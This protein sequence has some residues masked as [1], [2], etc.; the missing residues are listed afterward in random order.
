MRTFG[1]DAFRAAIA[2]GIALAEH[3]EARLRERDG[4]EV[5]TPASLG[6]VTFRRDGLD[7]GAHTRLSAATVE[8][9]YAAPS[10]TVVGGRVVLRLCTINPRTSFEEIEETIARME[11]L[12]G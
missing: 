3:A 5:V 6:I 10:T 2:H 12:S 1:L 11:R 9:G 4:W 8:D 7:D